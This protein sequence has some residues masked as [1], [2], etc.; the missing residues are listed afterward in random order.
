MLSSV[1]TPGARGNKIKI[2][3]FEMGEQYRLRWATS[4]FSCHTVD[5]EMC[6]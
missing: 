1:D 5:S 6:Y 4:S 3:L 2:L